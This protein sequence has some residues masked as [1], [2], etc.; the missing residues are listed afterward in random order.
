[1]A[2]M[3]KAAA[4]QLAQNARRYGW[5]KR[6]ETEGYVFCPCCRERVT[7]YKLPWE[8]FTAATMDAAVI[9]HLLDEC[10]G[11]R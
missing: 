11:G 5:H 7:F 9:A 8:R 2:R 4:K 6:S 3:T 1:M 10:G